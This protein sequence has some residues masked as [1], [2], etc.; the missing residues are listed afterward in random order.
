MAK[1][2]YT[3]DGVLIT[4]YPLNKERI[5]IGR[6]KDNH[7]HV[8]DLAVSGEHAVITTIGRDS[9]LEDLESTNGTL[10][11][12]RSVKWYALQEGDEIQLGRARL[13]Y[14]QGNANEKPV[15]NSF[16]QTIMLPMV[17]TEEQH[18]AQPQLNGVPHDTPAVPAPSAD[19]AKVLPDQQSSASKIAGVSLQLMQGAKPGREL[20]ITKSMTT[21][22]KVGVQVAVITKRNEGY[23]LAHIE[24]HEHPKL[25]GESIGTKAKLLKNEDLLELAGVQ[26][27][28]KQQLS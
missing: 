14:A 28:F 16:A 22:G 3:L 19:T 10:I 27:R 24:G 5:S 20:F 25:N 13:K 9:F 26:M 11:N 15:E 12:G 2:I 4:E 7:I 17:E 1:L 23:Y 8:D 6:R 21:L 18:A